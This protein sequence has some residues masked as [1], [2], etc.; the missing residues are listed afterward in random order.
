FPGWFRAIENIPMP[1]IILALVVLLIWIPFKNSVTG[2]GCYA[3]GSS[4]QAAYMSGVDIDRSKLAAFTLAGLFAS[5]GG[6][7]LALQTGTGNADIPMAGT[8]TLNAIA[9]VVI[10]GT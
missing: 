10:G 1:L 4:E 2:R 3:I 8:Y 7:Y 5:I 9:A 6:I